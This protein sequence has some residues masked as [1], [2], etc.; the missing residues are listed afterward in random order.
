MQHW[1]PLAPVS[2]WKMKT[3]VYKRLGGKSNNGAWVHCKSAAPQTMVRNWW[4]C[5]GVR[6]RQRSHFQ[7]N[8]LGN[9]LLV[10]LKP[11]HTDRQLGESFGFSCQY[12]ST[13]DSYHVLSQGYI[14]YPATCGGDSCDIG[15]TLDKLSTCLLERKD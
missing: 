12:P 9:E 2:F 10:N 4:R 15:S 13:S 1:P 3:L 7:P 6:P 11:W 14:L 8:P 5:V